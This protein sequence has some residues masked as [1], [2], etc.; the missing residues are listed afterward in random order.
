MPG[1]AAWLIATLGWRGGFQVY[2]ALTVAIVVPLV[3]ALVVNRP[4]DLGLRPDGGAPPQ[5]PPS[6]S[7]SQDLH[8]RTAE[9]LRNRNFWAIALPFALAFSSLSAVLIHL[10]PY[11]DDLG[12]ASDRG[13]VI[14]SAA[15]GAGALGK[16]TFGYLADRVDARIAIWASLGGQLLGIS[17]FMRGGGF[18]SLL[19]AA[20]VFGFSMGGVV[21]LQGAVTAQS[22]GRLSFGKAMGLLRPVQIPIHMLGVPLAGWIFDTTGSYDLAFEIFAG[23]YVVGI[24]CVGALR[25]KSGASGVGPPSDG[26]AGVA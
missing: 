3:A 14:L 17:L 2:A 19:A 24:L 21:P 13:W 8:W 23:F 20:L 15:A 11:A 16:P 10:I 5:D 1:V 12:I 6:P 7:A 4:E 26:E 22:F 9:L 25:P 18:D